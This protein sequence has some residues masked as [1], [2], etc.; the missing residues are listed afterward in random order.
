MAK[1]GNDITYDEQIVVGDALN[2]ALAKR[3]DIKSGTFTVPIDDK[4][5]T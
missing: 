3:N 4:E 5:P 2:K 1:G